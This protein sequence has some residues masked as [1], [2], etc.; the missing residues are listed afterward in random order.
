MRS[1]ACRSSSR[2]PSP[3]GGATLRAAYSE[4]RE[5]LWTPGATTLFTPA[6]AGDTNLKV[7]SAANFVVGD[8]LTL[9]G[10][11]VKI[12]AVGTQGRATTLAAAAAAGA[13]NIRVASVTGLI[14]NSTI[15]VGGQSVQVT[16]VGT[17]GASG[18][19][20]TLAAPLPEAAASGAAVRYD[21][22]GVTIDA[23]LTA[24]QAAGANVRSTPGAD[25]R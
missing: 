8:T 2:A 22:T 14:A 5:F 24:A 12:T 9:G 10:A 1:A 6:A 15:T 17:Q 25:H 16:A 3:A 7:A 11:S 19:G 18:T 13:T 20:L 21:G 23:P 4:A